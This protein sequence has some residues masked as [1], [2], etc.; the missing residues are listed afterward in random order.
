MKWAVEARRIE[1]RRARAT[2]AA[3]AKA[4]AAG[5]ARAEHRTG[6]RQARQARAFRSRR[7]TI[8]DESGKRRRASGN[9]QIG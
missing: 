4:M 7:T 5:R 3:I 1:R 2:A 6:V 9:G 8:G